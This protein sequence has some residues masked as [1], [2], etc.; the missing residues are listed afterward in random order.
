[1]MNGKEIN[2]EIGTAGG[3]GRASDSVVEEIV[4]RNRGRRRRSTP[5][6]S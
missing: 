2:G 1:M 3:R 4:R 5:N 6:F